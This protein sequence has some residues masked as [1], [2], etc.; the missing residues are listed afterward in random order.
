MPPP[1]PVSPSPLT[2][3]TPFLLLTHFITMG[4]LD[5][6]FSHHRYNPLANAVSSSSNASRIPSCPTLSPSHALVEV[7][8]ISNLEYCTASCFPFCLPRPSPLNSVLSTAVR[9]PFKREVISCPA[10]A[11]NCPLTLHPTQS[12]GQIQSHSPQAHL[13]WPHL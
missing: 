5:S 4:V 6:S 10:S 12:K 1:Q 11:Q 9:D 3:A 8:N 2:A 7:T 13:F